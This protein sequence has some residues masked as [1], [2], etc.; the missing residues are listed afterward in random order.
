MRATIE[1]L[2]AR[3]TALTQ[4][5]AELPIAR[6]TIDQLLERQLNLDGDVQQLRAELRDEQAQRTELQETVW[7]QREEIARLTEQL[8]QLQV[9]LIEIRNSS[10][11]L[12][13][14]KTVLEWWNL[15]LRAR[16]RALSS[17]LAELR[18][19]VNRMTRIRANIRRYPAIVRYADSS[20]TI[21]LVQRGPVT[22]YDVL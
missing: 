11:M 9:E 20:A 21:A 3:C 1:E 6:R 18:S 4:E 19:I 5:I 7:A 22:I 8:Q 13:R 17:E 2:E 10:A 16:Q 14:T 12:L 15:A